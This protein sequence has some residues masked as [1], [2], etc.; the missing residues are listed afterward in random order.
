MNVRL[1]LNRQTLCQQA[2]YFGFSVRLKLG[3]LWYE[4]L[5]HETIFRMVRNRNVGQS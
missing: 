1:L 2:G 5:C 3:G 4:V